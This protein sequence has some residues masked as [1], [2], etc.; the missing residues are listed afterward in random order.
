M[1]KGLLRGRKINRAK[2]P[3]SSH[4]NRLLLELVENDADCWC[5]CKRRRIL[6]R[7]LWFHHDITELSP[8][9]FVIINIYIYIFEWR[10]RVDY[11]LTGFNWNS[12][13][14]FSSAFIHLFFFL[15]AI[16][17]VKIIE[18]TTFILFKGLS[19][20]QARDTAFEKEMLLE[21]TAIIYYYNIYY[22]YTFHDSSRPR[23]II[24]NRNDVAHV[25]ISMEK[26]V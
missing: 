10:T 6:S 21:T 1:R 15:L 13:T 17:G 7:S 24:P 26:A 20:V 23:N 5:Y 8:R 11:L 9:R 16:T 3:N 19:V 18:N 25:S 12:E 4:S 2:S 14:S 22:Y